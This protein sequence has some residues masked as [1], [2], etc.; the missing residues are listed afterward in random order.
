MLFNADIVDDKPKSKYKVYKNDLKFK[1]N[2][3]IDKKHAIWYK[4]KY[5]HMFDNID[6]DSLE[7]RLLDYLKSGYENLDLSQ[8]ELKL[9]PNLSKL[10]DL[11]YMNMKCLFI[12]E[13]NLTSFP[14][15]SQYHNLQIIDISH[16]KLSKIDKL[17]SSIVELNCKHNE[18][19]E[20]NEFNSLSENCPNL[21]RLEC[22]NNK[23]KTIPHYEKL[24]NLLC[25]HNEIIYLNEYQHL[26]HLICTNNKLIK[27]GNYENLKYLDCSNNNINELGNMNNLIDLIINNTHVTKLPNMNK[28]KYIEMFGTTNIQL[29]YF[30]TLNDLFCYKDSISILSQKYT[31]HKKINITKHKDKMLHITFEL[32]E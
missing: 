3:N 25:C 31:L 11:Q 28:I 29:N 13:N 24:M 6:L 10:N 2:R 26:N 15:L 32:K 22:S 8:I 23:L 20:L 21:I 30:E 5:E 19:I 9:F 12:S 14:D 17:P 18:L 7:Y 16:N 27:I 4:Q 1:K